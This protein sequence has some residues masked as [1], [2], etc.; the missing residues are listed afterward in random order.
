MN[1]NLVNFYNNLFAI[2]VAVY[3]IITAVV[4]VFIQLIYSKYILPSMKSFFKDHLLIISFIISILTLI[5]TATGSFLLSIGKHNIFPFW[6]LHS[7]QIFAWQYTGIICVAVM[8]LSILFFLIFIYKNFSY[9]RPSRILLLLSQKI[10]VSEIRNFLL[11]KYGI[12][13]LKNELEEFKI[14][15]KTSS[16]EQ[17]SKIPLKN[18]SDSQPQHQADLKNYEKLK[19]TI[20]DAKDPLIP[21]RNIAVKLI[22]EYDLQTLEEVREIYGKITDSFLEHIKLPQDDK[23]WDPNQKIVLNYCNYLLEHTN[24]LLAICNKENLDVVKLIVV[25]M[26]KDLAGSLIKARHQELLSPL[27]SF[28]KKVADESITTS[29]TIFK[30]IIFYYREI[31]ENFIEEY[32]RKKQEERLDQLF[33]DLGWIGERLLSKKDFEEKPLMIDYEYTTEYDE[34]LETLLSLSD[35]YNRKRPNWYPLLFDAVDVVLKKIIELY[36][37]SENKK[38]LDTQN[39]KQDIYRLC[40]VFYSFAEKAMQVGN[41]KGAALAFIRLKKIY[42]LLCEKNLSSRAE[43][44]V[45]L[46]IGLGLLSAAHNKKL[47]PVDLSKGKPV[48]EWISDE[49]LDLDYLPEREMKNSIHH[50]YPIFHGKE[51]EAVWKFITELGN[52]LQTNFDFNFDWQTGEPYAEDDPR[53]Q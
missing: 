15:I 43:D 9:L 12:P 19:S 30:E 21:I 17:D 6:Y 39:L 46:L 5:F 28:W 40:N 48:K 13:P 31:L 27:S 3:G 26:S 49:L 44:L 20:K 18:D 8:L 51:H 45:D 7:F 23:N 25:G 41:S 10:K 42:E 38:H 16:K 2:E 32:E 11:K 35:K 29:S 34:L 52:K 22:R 14:Y 53:R 33:G 47:K 36:Q 1:G 4:L 37:G 50:R 24:S